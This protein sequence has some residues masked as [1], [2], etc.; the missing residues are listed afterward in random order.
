MKDLG[1][2]GKSFLIYIYSILIGTSRAIKKKVAFSGSADSRVCV[3]ED[4]APV[5]VLISRNNA[6]GI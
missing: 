6:S 1:Y 4:L 5:T 3:H 2:K